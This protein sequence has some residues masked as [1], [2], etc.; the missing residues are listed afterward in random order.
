MD[1]TSLYIRTA[2]TKVYDIYQVF[3]FATCKCRFTVYSIMVFRRVRKKCAVKG[4]SQKFCS[5]FGSVDLHVISSHTVIRH[6]IM[7][8]HTSGYWIIWITHIEQRE[9]ERESISCF[10]SDVVLVQSQVFFFAKFGRFPSL[11]NAVNK[12]SLVVGSLVFP[13]TRSQ[14]KI[15]GG[16]VWKHTPPQPEHRKMAKHRGDT[17]S[18]GTAGVGWGEDSGRWFPDLTGTRFVESLP[19]WVGDLQLTTSVNHNMKIGVPS[20][21]LIHIYIYSPFWRDFWIWFSFSHGGIC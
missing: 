15:G 2:L 14:E 3:W 5:A 4:C 1:T 16:I 21:K 9:R 6:W 17:F 7:P 18:W 12:T 10:P 20:R 19:K 11:V 13:T 8:V